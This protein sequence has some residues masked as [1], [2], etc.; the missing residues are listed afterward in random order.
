MNTSKRYIYH[1][2][3]GH[4]WFAV[5]TSELKKLGIADRITSFSYIRG[6]TAYLEEDLDMA[7][8]FQAYEARFGTRPQYRQTYRERTPIRNYQH[9]TVEAI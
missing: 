7:T 3:P 5:K 2:D 4:G 6:G 8:F 9:Y 1:T